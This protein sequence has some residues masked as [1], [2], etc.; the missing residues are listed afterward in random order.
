MLFANKKHI[1]MVAVAVT[2][3]FLLGIGA[4]AVTSTGTGYAAKAGTSSNIGKVN[5]QVLMTSHPDY[6][7][8]QE[9]MK[10]ESEQANKDFQE[11]TAN[12]ANEKEKQSYGQQLQQRLQMKEKE[13]LTALQDKINAAIKEV[14]D[15][16]GLTVVLPEQVVIFGGQDITDDVLKKFKK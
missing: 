2:A 14:A 11:K 6:A 5:M 13:L 16:K 10:Q 15:V 12:M 7:K 4:L 8:A 1:K 9:T 3:I